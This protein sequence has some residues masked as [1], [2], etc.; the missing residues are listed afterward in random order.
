MSRRLSAQSCPQVHRRDVSK[1]PTACGPC[2]QHSL[3]STNTVAAL[4]H[5]LSHISR[6]WYHDLHAERRHA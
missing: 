4:L 5:L 1:N 3:L 6:D 2:G